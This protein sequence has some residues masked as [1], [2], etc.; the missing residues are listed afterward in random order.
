MAQDSSELAAGNFAAMQPDVL[1]HILPK[2]FSP[3]SRV[4]IYQ[5]S[6]SF[7]EREAAEIDEQLH[8]FYA[9]WDSHGAPVKGWAKLLFGQFIVVMADE[10]A[11]GVSGCS[12]DGMVRIIKSLERQYSVNFFDRLTLTFLVNVKAQM[13]PMG[14]VAYAL[15]KGFVTP[16]TPFF[17]NTILTKAELETAWLVPLKES[18]LWRKVAPT[19]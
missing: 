6:R 14:Q 9:H 3:A 15:E 4:W 19:V 2:D 13:L 11:T 12:T 5:G 16:D 10:G 18:W 1:Q 8:L 17:N 7:S